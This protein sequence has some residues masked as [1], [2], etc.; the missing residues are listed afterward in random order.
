MKNI[1]YFIVVLGLVFSFSLAEAKTIKVNSYYK[2]STGKVVN[3]Y[4]K[5]SPNKTKIDNYSS[6]YNYNP[7]T[8]KKG[9]VNPYKY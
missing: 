2:P 1:L 7:Y 5:T 9:S 4:Y 8:D 3:S 6:K